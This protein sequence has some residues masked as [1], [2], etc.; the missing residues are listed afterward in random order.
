[1]VLG[2]PAG[3]SRLFFP[4]G[5]ALAAPWVWAKTLFLP[6]SEGLVARVVLV[7]LGRSS[8][9]STMKKLIKT[10][11]TSGNEAQLLAF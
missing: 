6:M 10:A 5:S 2:G 1:M 8:M 9:G 4:P 3:T 7:A 11:D